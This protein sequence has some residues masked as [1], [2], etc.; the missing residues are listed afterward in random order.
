MK[1]ESLVWLTEQH[2]APHRHYHTLQHI[3]EIFQMATRCGFSLSQNQ[4]LAIWFHDAVYDPQT[5]DNEEKSALAAR[6]HLQEDWNPDDLDVVCTL[7][8]DTKKHHAS[9]PESRAVLDLDLAILGAASARYREY[10]SQIREEYR[11]VPDE[12]Y[13]VERVRILEKFLGRARNNALFETLPSVFTKNA[14]D[15]LA[16]EI[17]LLQSGAMPVSLTSSDDR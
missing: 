6:H 13:G 10:A 4:T 12:K 3:A 17:G 11:F 16:W 14:R 2:R 5:M 7:I 1:S 8:L 15:N 9:H